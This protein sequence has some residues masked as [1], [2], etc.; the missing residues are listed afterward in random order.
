[1]RKV[2]IN[3]QTRI[4]IQAEENVDISEVIDE[5]DYNFIST[6]DNAEIV[7]TEIVDYEVVDSK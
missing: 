4:I 3:V 6:T 1:M 7:D 5:M 2:Y